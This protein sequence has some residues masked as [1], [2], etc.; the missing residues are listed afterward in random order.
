MTDTVVLTY[1]FGAAPSFC[2]QAPL[3]DPWQF[4]STLHI[5]CHASRGRIHPTLTVMHRN[6]EGPGLQKNREV[7]PA[8]YPSATGGTGST[9]STQIG[10]TYTGSQVLFIYYILYIIY[11]SVSIA[12]TLKTIKHCLKLQ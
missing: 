3:S 8:G 2:P 4:S 9:C 10:S 11:F 7:G 5:H 6:P 12:S 1:M